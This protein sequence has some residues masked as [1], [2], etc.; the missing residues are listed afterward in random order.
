MTPTNEQNRRFKERI[1]G[2][3]DVVDETWFCSPRVTHVIDP[4][5]TPGISLKDPVVT[6]PAIAHHASPDPRCFNVLCTFM[7]RKF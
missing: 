4:A 3:T 1:S 7:A 5:S 6:L 2:A